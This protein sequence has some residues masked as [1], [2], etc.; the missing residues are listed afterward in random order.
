R[1]HPLCGG[2]LIDCDE[3]SEATGQERWGGRT[4]VVEHAHALCVWRTGGVARGAWALSGSRGWAASAPGPGNPEAGEGQYDGPYQGRAQE[5]GDTADNPE[6]VSR[7][8]RGAAAVG[9]L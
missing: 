2:F 1:E 7:A 9:W 8:T 3:S 5:P 6:Q 4:A